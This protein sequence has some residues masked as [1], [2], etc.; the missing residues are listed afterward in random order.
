MYLTVPVAPT[1]ASEI[2]VS[3]YFV[4]GKMLDFICEDAG[5]F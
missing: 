2:V 4:A 1:Y 3:S 5:L